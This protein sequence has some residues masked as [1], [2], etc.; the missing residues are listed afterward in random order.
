[1]TARDPPD[2]AQRLEEGLAALAAAA[3]ADAWP[4]LRKSPEKELKTALKDGVDAVAR[5]ARVDAAWKVKQLA[6]RP[7]LE[8][9]RRALE[10]PGVGDPIHAAA[11]ELVKALGLGDP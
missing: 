11:R 5:L 6:A 10:E 9:L 8:A 7:H 2:L 3:H 4:E 1:V